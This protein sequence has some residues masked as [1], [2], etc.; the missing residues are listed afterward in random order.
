MCVY[1]EKRIWNVSRHMT[2]N[3][4]KEALVEE[5]ALQHPLNSGNRRNAWKRITRLGD[6][7][8]NIKLIKDYKELL[9]AVRK[10]GAK[11]ESGVTM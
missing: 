5:E 8:A 11:S 3:H 9:F 10:R 1:C 4:S 2:R 7:D 6:F